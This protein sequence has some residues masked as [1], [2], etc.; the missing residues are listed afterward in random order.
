MILLKADDDVGDVGLHHGLVAFDRAV[1]DEGLADFGT[2]LFGDL[3]KD[4]G[5]SRFLGKDHGDAFGAE[6]FDGGGK[7]GR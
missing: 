2:G 1:G 5:V 3:G 6:F 7:L 4:F